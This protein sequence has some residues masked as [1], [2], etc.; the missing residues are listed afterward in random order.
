MK[1]FEYE[2]RK[3]WHLPQ[4]GSAIR[5]HK[6][7]RLEILTLCITGEVLWKSRTVPPVQFKTVKTMFE[8]AGIV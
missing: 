5:P 8:R 7:G 4:F 2:G 6:E 3:F 1:T